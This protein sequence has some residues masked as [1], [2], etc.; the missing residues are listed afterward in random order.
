MSYEYLILFLL[1]SQTIYRVL[2]LTQT[3]KIKDI[4][5][6]LIDN[7]QLRNKNFISLIL[8]NTSL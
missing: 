1:E 6:S 4:K 5:K 7:H 3:K 2:S 8:E